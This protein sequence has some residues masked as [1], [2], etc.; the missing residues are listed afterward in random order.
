MGSFYYACSILYS[1]LHHD[2]SAY[3]HAL[4]R[5]YCSTIN[6]VLICIYIY[7][8]ICIYRSCPR[9]I[10][11]NYHYNPPTNATRLVVV[12][13]CFIP[14]LLLP[15]LLLVILQY[16]TVMVVRTYIHSTHYRIE[17]FVAI[18]KILRILCRRKVVHGGFV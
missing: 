18:L 9:P 1:I 2:C 3:F 12:S 8:Y 4:P 17:Y 13:S 7:I 6:V 15:L 16:K 10:N 14:S 11:N 5:T